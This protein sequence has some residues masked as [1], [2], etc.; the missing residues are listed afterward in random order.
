MKVFVYQVKSICV[1]LQVCVRERESKKNGTLEE[2]Q[3][4]K[5]NCCAM[6]LFK[7]RDNNK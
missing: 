6:Y 4:V 2:K 3:G 5:K 7:Q 1:F